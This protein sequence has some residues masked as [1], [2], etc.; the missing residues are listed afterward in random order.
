MIVIVQDTWRAVLVIVVAVL[1]R[2]AFADRPAAP[3]HPAAWQP[4]GAWQPVQPPIVATP[5]PERP[6]RRVAQSFLDLADS[7][8][9]VVR[10]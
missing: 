10:R 2:D 1:L 3:P 4:P 8:I 5:E 7:V 9:G 6:L